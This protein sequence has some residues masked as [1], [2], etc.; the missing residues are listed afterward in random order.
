[1]AQFQ[2]GHKKIPGSG[3]L[4]GM[5]QTSKGIR[6][7]LRRNISPTQM[8]ELWEFFLDKK[9]PCDIR[10]IAFKLA[11]YYMYGRPPKEPIDPDDR[12]PM[13]GGPDFDTSGVPTRH[14]PVM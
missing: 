13:N 12:P 10:F 6:D 8:K 9:R 7:F 4:A 3:R 5:H 2:K 14:E 11:L 1:M